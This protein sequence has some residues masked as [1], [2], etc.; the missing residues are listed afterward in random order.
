MEGAR[1]AAPS[2]LKDSPLALRGKLSSLAETD[3]LFP[4][5]PPISA[6]SLTA[7]LLNS[8]DEREDLRFELT[9]SLWPFIS[10]ASNFDESGAQKISLHS[11]FRTGRTVVPPSPVEGP[12][13]G[14]PPIPI[15]K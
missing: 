14:F 3:P 7:L 4:P 8:D 6:S 9:T 12:S 15:R 1:C 11:R 5:P 13:A 10:P 2:P